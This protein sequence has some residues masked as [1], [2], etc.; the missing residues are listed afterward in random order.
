MS[1][2]QADQLRW[3]AEDYRAYSTQ[4][5]KW[6][7]ELIAKMGLKG[8]EHV[9]D[10]GC[11]DGELTAEIAALVPRGRVLGIDSSP[12]MIELARRTYPPQEFPNLDWM[13]MDAK[14]IS[15][16]E[17]FDFAFSNAVLHWVD[18][19]PEVLRRVRRALKPG[20]RLLFQMGGRGNA[21]DMAMVLVSMLAREEWNRYFHGFVLPYHFHGAEEYREWLE[22]VGLRP[23][24][25]ELMNRDMVQKGREALVGWVRTTWIPFTQRIPEEKRDA[26]I[27]ELVDGYLEKH[28]LDEEGLA[29]MNAVR[30]EVEAEKP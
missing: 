22:E 13:L 19:Q 17:E 26:F 2:G 29:H 23:L 27:S 16:T 7:R 9:L 15:F 14:E 11:G 1:T 8:E 30:L 21:M 5:K 6:G 12:E 3:D 4:Q 24:R 28:P 25:V 10:I 20:G 18:D